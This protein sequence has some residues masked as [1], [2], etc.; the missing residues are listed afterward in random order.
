MKNIYLYFLAISLMLIYNPAFSQGLIVRGQVLDQQGMPLPGV[1]IS[2]KGTTI[3]TISDANGDFSLNTTQ[4]V[5]LLFSFVGYQ[6]VEEKATA[7]AMKIVL[8]ESAV[9]VDEVVVTALGIKKEKKALAYSVTEIKGNEMT[10]VKTSNLAVGLAGKVAGVNV[11]KP[12]S[13]VMGSSRIVIRGNGSLNGNNQPL[14]VIDGVPMDNSGNGQAGMWGGNDGG[15]GISSI[16]SEDIETISV[17]KG[18]TAAALYGSRAANGAIVITTKK[19]IAGKVK[20]EYGLSYTNDQPILKN[21]D[22]QWEYGCGANGLTPNQLA[23]AMGGQYGMTPEQADIVLAPQLASNMGMLSYGGK[24]DGSEVTQYDGVKRPYIAAGKNNFRNFYENGWALTNNIAI[25][26]GSEQAQYRIAVG[27]QRYHDLFPNSKLERDNIT[28]NLNAKPND[29]FSL[30]ANVM[31]VRERAKNRPNLGD[32][33]MN[34]NATLW[35]LPPNVDVRSL[36]ARVDENGGELLPAGQSWISNPY[37]VAYNRIQQDSKDRII[38]SLE[39]QYNF[40]PHWYLRGRA[41]GDMINRRTKDVIPYG[42]GYK[43]KGAISNGSF[44]NGELNVDAIAGYN[45]NFKD[46]RFTLDVFAGWNTMVSWYNSISANGQD[47]V[48]PGFNAIG[49]TGTTSGGHYFSDNYINSVF[50]QI[51]LS[52]QSML[53]LT[54]TGRNDWFSSLAYKN[55]NTDNHIFYPSVGLGFIVSQ[56]V[57]MPE[58]FPFLKLRGSWAESGGSVG[59]YQLGLTYGY[60]QSY[61]D[62]PIGTINPATI[63]NLNLKPLTSISYEGGLEARFFNNRLGIDATYYVRNTKN[64]IVSAGISYASGYQD[65]KINAGKVKNHGVELLLTATPVQ[66]RHFVWNSSLNFSYNKSEVVHIT[67]DIDEFIIETART[68]HDGDNCGPAYIYHEVG[69]PYGIIKGRAYKRNDKG[70][71]MFKNGLPMAGDIKKLGESVAPY[72]LGFNNSIEYRNFT[73]NFLIDAKFGNDLFSMTNAHMIS[74]GRHKATLPGREGGVVGKGVKEDGV[75]P[76][77]V[78]VS[79]MQY[80]MAL[81][82]ITEECIYDASFVKLRELSFGYNFPIKW[83]KPLGVEALYVAVVGRNLWNIYDNLPMVDPESSFNNGNAQGFESYGLPATRSIGFN[84]NVKF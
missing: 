18:G 37:F 49:N 84:I 12:A 28:L 56:A 19:G 5:S 69:Q 77:D 42:T 2:V 31:Y 50:G 55:K 21:N 72:T 9:E 6:S 79:A 15:D 10:R 35:L 65:V 57:E 26:G 29:R 51:V 73:L 33:I 38:G 45:R 46:G 11:V 60:N 36:E 43:P 47:F 52:Y 13:G 68:G 25:S 30:R 78:S 7:S 3:G 16:N 83:L 75:T 70:E 82:G 53:Y 14:Y 17:L 40:T 23:H 62:Y 80:Y 24:L 76:N 8:K 48:Q 1:S 58:W 74:F 34:G 54:M 64:D 39:L 81:A 41:G 67:E 20:V 22:F 71:I 61:K 27:D 66:N 44:Y 59:P 4:G 32:I 63:P